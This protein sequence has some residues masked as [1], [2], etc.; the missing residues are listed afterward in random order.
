MPQGMATTTALSEPQT[1]DIYDFLQFAPLLPIV[2]VGAALVHFVARP[3]SWS[4]PMRWALAVSGVLTVLNVVRWQLKRFT[5]PKPGYDVIK[6]VGSLELRQYRR[7]VVAETN[8]EAGFDAALDEGFSRLASY[9][10]GDSSTGRKMVMTAPVTSQRRQG[11]H[12]IS[13]VMPPNRSLPQLPIPNDPRV[14]V[15]ELPPRV[16]AAMKFHGRYD[17]ASVARA[18]HQL[19]AQ[20]VELGLKTRGVP[21]FAGYDAPATLPALRRNEVWVELET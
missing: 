21:I 17:G 7:L 12:T 15:C 14:R 13:F 9:I 11:A 4:R 3:R 18:E 10:Y 20:I 8:V 19:M 5:T 1:P 16:V 2:P 6:R